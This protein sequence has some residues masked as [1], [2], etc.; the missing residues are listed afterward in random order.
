MSMPEQSE[1]ID[2]K[3]VKAFAVFFKRY[4]SVSTLVVASLPIPVTA[5]GAIPTFKAHTKLLSVYT[6]LFCFLTLGF[7]FYSRHKLARVMFPEYFSHDRKID[8]LTRLG[9]SI[10]RLSPL[11]LIISSLVAALSYHSLLNFVIGGAIGFDNVLNVAEPQHIRY[12]SILML[13]YLSIFVTAEGAFI[14]MAIKEYLQD[15]VGLTEMNL[16]QG[17]PKTE[18]KII[19]DFKPISSL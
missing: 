4:M 3:R 11:L 12:S 9:R 1:P 5:L 18:I 10:I 14:L 19:N 13:L 16:I 15:L 8:R 17:P 2:P 6:P 7:I